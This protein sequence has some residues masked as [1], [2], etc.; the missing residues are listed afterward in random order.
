M[1][2]PLT[3]HPTT[4]LQHALSG[5]Y[6]NINI[7][8]ALIEAGADANEIARPHGIRP[9]RHAAA[10]GSVEA[11]QILLNAGACTILTSED[12][13]TALQAAV[14]TQNADLIQIL[15]DSGADVNAPAGTVYRRT[16]L[17]AAAEDRNTKILELLLSHGADVNAPA[18]RPDGITALQGAAMAGRL[19][20]V[21]ILLKAGAQINAPPASSEGRM[22]LGAAAESGRLVIVLLLLKNDDDPE[23]VDIRCERAA[24]LAAS[25]CQCV[26]ARIL[27]EHKTG[28]DSTR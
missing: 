5:R 19:K 9:L 26:I 12:K 4:A 27:R 23:G 1:N 24:K 16:A 14:A 15:L 22:A 25:N 28:P 17:Q 13:D 2:E 21:L 7:V 18:G 20:N 8:S 10:K 6:I 11:V 3:E